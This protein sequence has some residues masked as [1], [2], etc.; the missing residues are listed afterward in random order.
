MST[1]SVAIVED[2]GVY[3]ELLSDLCRN[4]PELTF[5]GAFDSIG[6]ACDGLP[7]LAPDLVLMD[8]G[9][10]D[11]DGTEILQRLKRQGCRSEFLVLTVYDDDKHLFPALEAGAVGYILKE[12]ADENGLIAAIKEVVRGGAP[13]SASI[14]RR[15]LNR[16]S[17]RNG[18]GLR[19]AALTQ[20]E[21][22]VLEQ[23][24]RGYSAKK[25]AQILDI[26]Y[27][28]VRCHQKNIYKKLQVSSV[29]E[30]LSAINALPGKP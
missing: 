4:S 21:N 15:V 1:I 23:L 5:A 12:Q 29:L 30:A 2:S 28:T 25:V 19:S 7:Q 3:R 11:G 24:A 9:L 26:S 22:E 10:P 14:A 18:D 8:L 20:R 16:F 27:E 13:M 17:E 6:A